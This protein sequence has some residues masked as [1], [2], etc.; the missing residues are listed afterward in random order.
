MMKQKASD[1]NRQSSQLSFRFQKIWPLYI[2]DATFF[3]T[4]HDMPR[5]ENE[6]Q[7]LVVTCD[8]NAY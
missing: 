8:H 6:S 2:F 1:D 7:F 4:Q 5:G 3:R